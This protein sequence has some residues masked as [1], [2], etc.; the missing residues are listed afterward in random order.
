MI[1]IYENEYS[2][3][4]PEAPNF[5]KAAAPKFLVPLALA[6][7]ESTG[8]LRL[9]LTGKDS[10]RFHH[11]ERISISVCSIHFHSFPARVCPL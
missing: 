1:P 3:P 11:L 4:K 7:M 9:N 2:T 6:A 10:M 8:W 5:Q